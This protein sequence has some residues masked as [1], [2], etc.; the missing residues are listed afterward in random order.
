MAD[1]RASGGESHGGGPTHRALFLF[2]SITGQIRRAVSPNPHSSPFRLP[3]HPPPPHSLPFADP[4]E[5]RVD[6]RRA[7][8]SDDTQGL[9][10]ASAGRSAHTSADP[11]PND[12][13]DDGSGVVMARVMCIT[14]VAV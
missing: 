4:T 10:P 8:R 1:G 13:D 11:E 14:V 5:K 3:H 7:C 2:S 6:R 12:G 9:I